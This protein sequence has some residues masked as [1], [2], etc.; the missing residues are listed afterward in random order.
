MLDV[1]QLVEYA[2]EF[3]LAQHFGQRL[4]LFGTGDTAVVLTLAAFHLLIVEFDSIDA[5]ILL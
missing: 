5:H 2:P 4:V 1:G 3:V